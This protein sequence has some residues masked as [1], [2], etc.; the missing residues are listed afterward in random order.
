MMVNIDPRDAR[1]DSPSFVDRSCRK[2][3]EIVTVG[4]QFAVER[5]QR[6]RP[7]TLIVEV[8][9]ALDLHAAIACVCWGFPVGEIGRFVV[10]Q[11]MWIICD[12]AAPFAVLDHII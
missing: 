12:D 9:A 6:W 10:W 8:A 7:P 5:R 4:A 3:V 11:G 2:N 1:L